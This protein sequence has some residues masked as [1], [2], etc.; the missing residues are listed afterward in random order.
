VPASAGLGWFVSAAGRAETRAGV[1]GVENGENAPDF[2][3]SG[4][5]GPGTGDR[6]VARGS[7]KTAETSCDV[8]RSGVLQLLDFLLYDVRQPSVCFCALISISFSAAWAVLVQELVCIRCLLELIRG[9]FFLV[10]VVDPGA[11]IRLFRP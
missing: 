3:G 2:G 9:R 10:R 1:R 8:E 7:I 11:P 5:G 6:G 4:R